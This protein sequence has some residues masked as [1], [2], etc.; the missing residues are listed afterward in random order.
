[1]RIFRLGLATLLALV[2]PF[3]TAVQAQTQDRPQTILVLDA[4]GSM[5]GQIDGVAKITIA[6]DVVTD[7]LA[8]F[9]ADVSL[10]LTVY[11]HREKG[12][13]AD[14]ETVVAPAPGTAATIAAAV[15]GIQPRGKTPMTDAV[16]AAAQALKYTEERAT[17]ILVSDGIETCNPD[18][19]AAALALEAA[20][21]DFTAHVVGFDVEGDPT[22][23]AQL[24]CLAANTGGR[25]I[26]ASN[27]LELT[28]A[29]FTV[30][31]VDP[32]PEPEFRFRFRST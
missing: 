24:Q 27:A 8:T 16:I 1:M 9:P 15:R 3:V 29:L 17:V 20:G 23:Q 18:P 22:A 19:C 25:Y 21:V 26:G 7:L 14:I 28:A 12:N 13:C 30:V 31:A 32:E 6:Q 2:S 5:W 4:S 11:G 10:G